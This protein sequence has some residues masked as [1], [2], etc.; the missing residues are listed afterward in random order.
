MTTASQTP[1]PEALPP[2]PTRALVAAEGVIAAAMKRG[3]A[4]PREL[5]QA[6]QDAG[7][8]FDA[9]AAQDIADAAAEQAHA[10]AQ[11]AISER[12][13]QL[14]RVAGDHRKLTAVMRLLEGRP[15]THLLTVA[16]IAAAAEYAT[17]PFDSAPMTLGWTG[18]VDIPGPGDTRKKAVI[19]CMSS[20][21]G[22]AVL[23]VEGDAR[24][25]LASQLDLELRDPH[26]P[27]ATEGCGTDHDLGG[28]D[29]FGWSR[30]EI[31]SLGEGARWY[32]SDMC[33]MDALSRAGHDVA[34]ADRAAAG[35]PDEQDSGPL[36]GDDAHWAARITLAETDS[37][38]TEQ[39]SDAE[40]GAS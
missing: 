29:L 15:G 2:E 37:E 25:N 33:V 35:D 9:Q 13:R 28:G 36:Y 14:A 27:C 40:G 3:A 8:L 26:A 30:L 24:R 6:E 38:A 34:A 23:V 12:G 20:Y 4:T 17:T 16:E 32:C 11:A 22:R 21:G 19:E 7:L 39:A 18:G 5:A 10:E 31:A 1:A